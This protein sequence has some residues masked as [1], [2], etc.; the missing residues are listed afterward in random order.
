VKRLL[1]VGGGDLGREVLDWALAVLPEERDWEV[2]GFIDSRTNILDGFH[3]P[4]ANLGDP[5]TFPFTEDDRVVCAIGEPKA[6][7]HY[8]RLLK[9]RGAKFGSVIHP[10]VTIGSGSRF[11]EGCVLCPGAVV[12]NHVTLGNFVTLN[13]LSAVGHDAVLG[14]GCTLSPHADVN[15]WAV[16]G[17]GVFLGAHAAVLPK[18]HVGEY[19]VVGAGSVVLK[20]TEP[21]STVI[22]VPAKRVL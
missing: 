20:K 4:Y 2:G 22:G 17:E 6:K 21:H 9:S 7:L 10:S 15:G 18:A 16:L 14:D 3:V 1:I 12:T 5:Q 8:C 13:V 11:G 19:T